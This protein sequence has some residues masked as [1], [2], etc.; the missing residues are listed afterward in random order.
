MN[1]RRHRNCE[2]FVFFQ[3]E[4]HMFIVCARGLKKLLLTQMG[5]DSCAGQ[6]STIQG[7]D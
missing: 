6:P 5:H 2:L 4:Y 1:H 3:A 7:L